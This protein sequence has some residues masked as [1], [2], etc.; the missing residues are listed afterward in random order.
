[1]FQDSK[2]LLLGNDAIYQ[3]N[4]FNNDATG[5]KSKFRSLFDVVNNTST[6]MGRR[7]LK[8]MLCYPSM[9]IQELQKRYDCIEELITTDTFTSLE[10]HLKGSPD[11]ERLIRKLSLG[12]LHPY[13]F[14]SFVDFC[15]Q[16][17][18]IVKLLTKTKTVKQLIPE[19]KVLNN[20]EKFI[21]TVTKSL[22]TTECSKYC[23]NDIQNCIFLSNVHPDLDK[24]QK[25]ITLSSTIMDDICEVLSK[26]IDNGPCKVRTVQHKQDGYYIKLSKARSVILKEKLAT[27][28]TL[29][30]NENVNIKVNKLKFTDLKNDTKIFIEGLNESHDIVELRYQMMNLCKEKLTTFYQDCFST[31]NTTFKKIVE[32]I[33]V[34][35]FLKSSAKTAKLY[36]YVKPNICKKKIANGYIRVKGLRHPIIERIK[37]DCEYVPYDIELGKDENYKQGADLLEGMMIYGINSC[38]K[39]SCMKAIGLLVILAQAGMY[40]PATSYKFAPYSSLFARITS[41]DNLYKGLSS[42]ALE[43]TELNAILRRTGPKTLI[44]GDEVCR[45]TE[46]ISGTAIVASTII[47]L[48]KT[49]STFI[50]ATHL[51]GIASMKRIQELANVKSFHLTV[52]YDEQNDVLIFDR[53]LKP[54]SGEPIYGVLVAKY[55]IQNNDFIKLAQEI[56]NEILDVPNEVLTAKTSKYNSTVYVHSCQ[57]CGKSYKPTDYMGKLDTHHI[58]HQKDCK[59][60]F[61]VEK[62]HLLKDSKSNLVVLCKE[63]HYNV[64]HD[65]LEITGYTETSKGRKLLFKKLDLDKQ[66]KTKSPNSATRTAIRT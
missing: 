18:L 32:F 44:I 55:I 51:H 3:L 37:T 26:L 52:N 23:I 36:N 57:V 66:K 41:N 64:H 28:K 49:G 31:Y 24:L 19:K 63:C 12:I 48:S 15:N 61:V 56:K 25:R 65:K 50:F 9:N 13:E 34:V 35:D 59:D 42:F 54:G 10:Q 27:M 6:A 43:M 60:G 58:N 30:I 45:G 29:T 53:Q 16:I 2:Y 7:Y 4:V 21:N 22:N 62:P 33:S 46:H 14:V 40:V 17:S 5:V 20:L 39:S 1:V 47:N 8:N 38:G 11:L